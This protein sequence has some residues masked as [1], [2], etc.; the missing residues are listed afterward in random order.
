M[1]LVRLAL[2]FAL[3]GAATFTSAAVEQRTTAKEAV[4]AEAMPG[5]VYLPPVWLARALSLGHPTLAADYYWMGALQYFGRPLNVLV[6]YKDLHRYIDLVNALD[7]DFHYAYHFGGV[8]VPWNKGNWQWQNVPASNAILERGLA[9]FPDDWFM[10]MQLGFNRGILETDYEGAA[11]AYRHGAAAPGS[12]SWLSGLVTRL[13]ATTGSVD[14]AQAYAEEVLAH[15]KDPRL[16]KNMRF[17]L[18]QLQSEKNRDRIENAITAY[19]KVHGVPP[20][21]VADLV[22]AGLLPAVPKDPLGG[23]YEILH[24]HAYVTSLR[25]GRLRV[26]REKP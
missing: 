2:V 19:R 15:S 8:S 17:R 4:F 22:H 26:F 20:E 21:K 24:G 25:Q 7:P 14:A 3:L 18:R 10:W 1:Q 6:Y 11:D 9:R 13:L 23:T 16:K 12:P 5:P